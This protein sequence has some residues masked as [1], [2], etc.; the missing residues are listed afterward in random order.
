MPTLDSLHLLYFR[1]GSE[2]R[3]ALDEKLYDL[4]ARYRDRCRLVVRHSDESGSLLGGWVSGQVP[5][6]LFVRNG[7]SVAQ[8]VGDIPSQEIETLLLHASA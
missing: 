2:P 5:T 7:R 8:I 3:N 4:A 6:V 1:P